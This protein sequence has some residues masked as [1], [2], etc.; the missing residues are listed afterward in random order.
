MLCHDVP[1]MA[2]GNLTLAL[3]ALQFKLPA[4]PV[5]EGTMF[6]ICETFAAGELSPQ[7]QTFELPVVDLDQFDNNLKKI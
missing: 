7:W 3:L 5:G 6:T 4:H 1:C 2:V